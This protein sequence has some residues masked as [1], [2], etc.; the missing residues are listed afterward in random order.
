MYDFL[1]LIFFRYKLVFSKKK[2][3]IYVGIVWALS[4]LLNSPHAL[5]MELSSNDNSSKPQCVWVTTITNQ[6]T[7]YAVAFLEFLG[8]YF[9]PVFVTCATFIS[10]MLTVK[11]PNSLFLRHR[12]NAGVRLLRMC[13]F[14]AFV[15]AFCWFPNQL[16]Y[17]L[18]KFHVTQLNVPGHHATVVLCMFN[19]CVNPWVYCVTNKTYRRK[20]FSLFRKCFPQLGESETSTAFDGST[21]GGEAKTLSII[22]SSASCILEKVKHFDNKGVVES[23]SL[24]IIELSKQKPLENKEEPQMGRICSPSIDA[25]NQ[26]EHYHQQGKHYI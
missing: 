5:E 14:T 4:C 26:Q 25:D 2:K 18:F 24:E 16:Y 12:G 3:Y 10:L 13:T 15:L 1:I 20:F 17:L 9:L 11:K 22:R 6:K 21:P 8:K 19:S 23:D 7:R